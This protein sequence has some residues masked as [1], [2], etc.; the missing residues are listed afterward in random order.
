M[1]IQ[2]DLGEKKMGIV[3]VSSPEFLTS[4]HLSPLNQIFKNYIGLFFA[5]FRTSSYQLWNRVLKKCIN[6]ESDCSGRKAPK[7]SL[8][9]EDTRRP[10]AAKHST[11]S[12][13]SHSFFSWLLVEFWTWWTCTDLNTKCSSALALRPPQ[14]EPDRSINSS[15]H[16]I[17][18][19]SYLHHMKM[20]QGKKQLK[21]TSTMKI[22]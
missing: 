10:W 2:F 1:N 22:T 3:D 8:N 9:N 15:G 7:D 16:N 11:M 12:I 14:A 6:S 21:N 4:L 13:L 5:R 20:R 17:P 19:N 18:F